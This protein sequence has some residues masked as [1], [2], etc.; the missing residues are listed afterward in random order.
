M[1]RV[2]EA[3]EI[4]I[5][6]FCSEAKNCQ[7]NCGADFTPVSPWN[8]DVRNTIIGYFEAWAPTKSGCGKVTTSNIALGS[9]SHINAAFGYIEPGTYTIYPIDNID[10]GYFRNIT[11]LKTQAPFTKVWLSLGGWTFSDN[12]TATQPVWGDLASTPEKRAKFI[13]GL[14]KFMTNWGFDGV[15]LDWEYPTAP[16]RRGNPEDTKNY[17]ALM[18]D[19]KDRFDKKGAGWGISFTAPASYWYMKWFDIAGMAEVVDFV[20]LMTYDM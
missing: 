4:V 9:V 6:D 15:D 14:D 2:E 10:V 12:D 19:I 16:D 11:N 17:V 20:N 7:S 18:K 1:V 8:F 3:T 13:D 5:Q